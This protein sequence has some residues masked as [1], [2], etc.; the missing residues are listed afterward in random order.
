MIG[1]SKKSN[2]TETTDQ[3][4]DLT[5]L[6]QLNIHSCCIKSTG[7]LLPAGQN[8]KFLAECVKWPSGHFLGLPQRTNV[9][10]ALYISAGQT[11]VWGARNPGPWNKEKQSRSTGA[12]STGTGLGGGE[13]R[14][15]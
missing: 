12:R 7:P 3:S 9:Y 11:L 14:F 5:P 4:R 2:L 15:L 1:F 10:G 13:G 8:P 6:K